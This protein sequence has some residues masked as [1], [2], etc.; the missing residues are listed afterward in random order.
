MGSRL[1]ALTVEKRENKR[2]LQQICLADV[3]ACDTVNQ[4][5]PF[6]EEEIE[7]ALRKLDAMVGDGR[8]E[9]GKRIGS[10]FCDSFPLS[11]ETGTVLLP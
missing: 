10:Q 4:V 9:Q 7:Q 3:Q 6:E 8:S 2:T 5:E 11:A 1:A